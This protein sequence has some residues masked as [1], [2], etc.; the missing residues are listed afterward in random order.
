MRD[1]ILLTNDR[2]IAQKI[3][4]D[5]LKHGN[6]D[7]QYLGEGD[8]NVN[9]LVTSLDDTIVIKLSRPNREHKAFDAYQ[10]EWWC[11]R[12]ARELQIPAPE[13]LAVGKDGSRAYQIQ[14][15]VQGVPVADLAGN[16]SFDEAQRL[17]VWNKL[18]EYGKKIN[19][20]LVRGFGENILDEERG[21][22]DG[23]WQKYLQYNI[24]SLN[25]ADQLI[26]LGML[27]PVFSK[28]I[29]VTFQSLQKKKF[30]FGLCHNDL[31]LRNAILAP[32]GVVYLLDW[33]TAVARIVPHWDINKVVQSSKP[34]EKTLQAFLDGYGIS[35]ESYASMKPELDALNLLHE[36]DTFRWAIDNKPDNFEEY[37]GRAKEAVARFTR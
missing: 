1:K 8:C 23:S 34:N 2:S 27:T 32:D 20:I 10:K 29:K 9:F 5:F 12:K 14:T 28:A 25:D 26:T 31:A 6:F 33:D 19:S 7:V 24:D 36:I 15:Y 21:I 16:S 35:R 17:K 30:T 3:A 11:L 37:V 22:F 13:V 18:G 4:Q